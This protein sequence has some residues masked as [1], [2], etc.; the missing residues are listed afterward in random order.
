MQ[1]YEITMGN[2]I[3][4]LIVWIDSMSREE[5]LGL[6]NKRTHQDIKMDEVDW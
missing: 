4:T 5:L 2:M 1:E 6:Y 3:D